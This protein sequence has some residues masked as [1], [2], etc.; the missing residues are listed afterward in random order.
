M[1]RALVIVDVQNDFCEGGALPVAGGHAAEVR[2]ADAIASGRLRR[3]EDLVVT[4]QD[5]HIAPGGH[6]ADHPDYI[7]TWPVHCRVGTGGA[8]IAEP[9]ASALAAA[10]VVAGTFHKG[11]DRAAYSGFEG[12]EVATGESLEDF[13]VGHGVTDV[14][15]CGLATDYCVRATALDAARLGFRTRVLLRYSAG[16]SE[17]RVAA[18][19]AE[20]ARAGVAVVSAGVPEPA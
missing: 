8:G 17:E 14:D 7:D 3:L 16:I 1:T 5:W 12:T 13:L 9:L 10:G 20:F 18:T 4:T 19:L 15:V 2:L 11:A 6:F